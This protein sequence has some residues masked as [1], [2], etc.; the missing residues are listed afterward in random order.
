MSIKSKFSPL[1]YLFPKTPQ[2]Q[3]I[4]NCNISV[5]NIYLNG[6]SIAQN[7]DTITIDVNQGLICDIYATK[8]GYNDSLH[9]NFIIYEN[10]SIELNL[11]T[12]ELETLYLTINSGDDGKFIIPFNQYRQVAY[13]WKIDWGDGTGWHT[14]SGLGATNSGI[15]YSN[16]E[17]NHTYTIKIKNNGI[18]SGWLQAFGFEPTATNTDTSPSS[19]VNKNKV[20]LVDGQL[21]SNMFTNNTTLPD[22]TFAYM[23]Q[24]CRNLKI[25]NDFNFPQNITNVGNYICQFMFQNCS[26]ID[27]L[28]NM[29]LSQ[30]ITDVGLNFCYGMFQNCSSLETMD[31]F[32]LP[33]NLVNMNNYTFAYMFQNNTLLTTLNNFNFPQNM[34]NAPQIGF[35]YSMFQNCSSLE[36]LG[37]MKIPNITS[38]NNNIISGINFVKFKSAGGIYYNYTT[39]PVITYFEQ[40]FEN[41][42]S[43]KTGIID[44]LSNW[45][46]ATQFMI[47]YHQQVNWYYNFLDKLYA[48]NEYINVNSRLFRNM[49]KNCLLLQEN[50]TSAIKPLS[51]VPALNI[52]YYDT[53]NNIA[54]TETRHTFEGCPEAYISTLNANWK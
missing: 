20:L 37:I 51:F 9:Q 36:N 10:K 49:F 40:T 17:V 41:C 22:Y 23:F 21:D 31:N 38:I 47:D 28:Q 14:Y 52:T 6:V 25:G 19:L 44:F 13:N 42:T 53:R 30:N 35:A 18:D 3:L 29:I 2:V 34:L 39:I 46:N 27:D 54:T 8:D 16:Y 48:Y 4:I 11:S 7:T 5:D 15:T 24:D 1:G 43:L 26:S 33:Q 45:N 32:N 50:L 12:S